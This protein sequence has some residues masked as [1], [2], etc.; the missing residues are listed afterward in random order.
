MLDLGWS[1][2]AAGFNTFPRP[3]ELG[4]SSLRDLLVHLE[5]RSKE[6]LPPM[7][8]KTF[9]EALEF[10]ARYSK[11]KARAKCLNVFEQ[12]AEQINQAP[13]PSRSQIQQLREEL[14]QR[15]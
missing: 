5:S 2:P 7:P 13:E 6:E 8:G 12:Y 1:G 3:D 14:L 11:G 4:L 10:A 9:G 15:L